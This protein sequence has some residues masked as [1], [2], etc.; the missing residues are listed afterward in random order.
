MSAI[1]SIKL[2]YTSLDLEKKGKNYISEIWLMVAY[3]VKQIVMFFTS[4]I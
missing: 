2:F 3:R 4:H 1:M